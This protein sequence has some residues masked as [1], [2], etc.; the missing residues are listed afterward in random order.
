M[1]DHTRTLKKWLS[2]DNCNNRSCRKMLC[3]GQ[4]SERLRSMIQMKPKSAKITSRTA[5]YVRAYISTTYHVVLRI[6]EMATSFT[7]DT[8]FSI[9]QISL[10]RW[11]DAAPVLFRW[12]PLEISLHKQP[13]RI[14][15]GWVCSSIKPKGMVWIGKPACWFWA[16]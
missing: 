12:A 14:G 6:A 4:S 11:H 15:P 16:R 10:A 1:C 5:M 7:T 9:S 8:S 3:Q 2:I 13:S